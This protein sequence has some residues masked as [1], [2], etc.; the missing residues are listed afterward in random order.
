MW[1]N[2][3]LDMYFISFVNPCQDD[4]VVVVESHFNNWV[5]FIVLVRIPPLDPHTEYSD[6]ALLIG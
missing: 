5:C 2:K 6:C 1:P 3:W 4:F